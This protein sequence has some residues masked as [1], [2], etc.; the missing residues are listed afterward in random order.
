MAAPWAS[1]NGFVSGRY[2]AGMIA[3]AASILWSVAWMLTI[4]VLVVVGSA[5]GRVDET[6]SWGSQTWQVHR[7]MKA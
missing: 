6:E 1:D 7:L 4:A 3:A 2:L 5:E